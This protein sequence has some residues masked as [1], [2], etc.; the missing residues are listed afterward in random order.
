MACRDYAGIERATLR[1]IWCW[2]YLL[3]YDTSPKVSTQLFDFHILYNVGQY[4]II[5]NQ[6]FIHS[7][8]KDDLGFIFYLVCGNKNIRKYSLFQVGN[9]FTSTK[10]LC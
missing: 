7:H 3:K 5:A 1:S 8:G 2:I 6:Q 10:R 4:K 9:I